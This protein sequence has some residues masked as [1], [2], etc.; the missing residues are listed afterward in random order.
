MKV[1]FYSTKE[2]EA[3]AF[4][5]APSAGAHEI[6]YLPHRLDPV[7]ARLAQGHDA[8]CI[9]VN[10]QADAET[11]DVLKQVGIKAVALRCDSAQDSITLR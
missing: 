11:L 2:Y 6:T 4:K 1:A 7:T 9:F 8:V 10:D 3:D 5:G